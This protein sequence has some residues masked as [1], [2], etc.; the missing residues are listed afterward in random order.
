MLSIYLWEKGR[1][2]RDDGDPRPKSEAEFWDHVTPERSQQYLTR[3]G[4]KDGGDGGYS[5]GTA[6]HKD[7][8]TAQYYAKLSH[9]ARPPPETRNVYL[10]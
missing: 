7:T 9:I 4:L 2:L 1:P 8:M 6:R 5:G 3:G 10:E